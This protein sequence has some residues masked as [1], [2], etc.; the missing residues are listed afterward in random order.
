MIEANGK[1][2]VLQCRDGRREG[3]EQRKCIPHVATKK[4]ERFLYKVKGNIARQRNLQP[5][6]AWECFFTW[7]TNELVFSKGILLSQQDTK[8]PIGN[9]ISTLQGRLD[10]FNPLLKLLMI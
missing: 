3:A 2:W 6:S 10:S 5:S 1:G 8:V 9:Y 7:I 4:D